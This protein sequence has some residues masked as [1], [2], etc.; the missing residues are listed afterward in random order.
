ME[1]GKSRLRDTIVTS[2][3]MHKYPASHYRI[4][5]RAVP[6]NLQSLSCKRLRDVGSHDSD[7][8]ALFIIN[9]SPRNPGDL[10]S[11]IL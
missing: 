6:K 11:T 8:R 7:W 10:D 4:L 9:R 1:Q 5:P 2:L 3:E